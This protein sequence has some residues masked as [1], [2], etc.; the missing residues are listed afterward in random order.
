MC[1]VFYVRNFDKC[2]SMNMRKHVVKRDFMHDITEIG[3]ACVGVLTGKHSH[4]W[5]CVLV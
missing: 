3:N 2:L 4:E 1:N 5:I